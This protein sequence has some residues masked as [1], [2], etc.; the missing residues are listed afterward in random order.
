MTKAG[1]PIRAFAFVI[2]SWTVCRIAATATLPIGWAVALAPDRQLYQRLTFDIPLSAA[3]DLRINIRN[4]A[5][6]RFATRPTGHLHVIIP[7]SPS[8]QHA[9]TYANSFDAADDLPSTP[10]RISQQ[11]RVAALE[12]RLEPVLSST[13]ENRRWSMD[14]WALVRNGGSQNSLANY[15]QLG[16]SQVGMR[17]Q[18]DLT[19]GRDSRVALYSRLSRA[20][21]S[22][23]A[24]EAALGVTYR[25]KR[26]LPLDIAIERRISLGIGARNAFAIIGATGFGPTRM[27]LGLQGEGYAQAGFVGFRTKDHFVDGKIALSKSVVGDRIAIGLA[28]S[29]GAQRNLT[30]LDIGPHIHMRFSTG[31]IHSR[32]AADWR[33]RIIGHAQPGSGP[34]I[35]LATSF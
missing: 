28:A 4:K 34:A 33:Q 11:Y 10:K 2:L 9:D 24:P 6:P 25:P 8:M 30:R 17:L 27:P 31:K 1:R 19:P 26:S 14:V 7:P 35:T 23:Y 5:I 20:L 29:G 16:A 18:Y 21:E 3:V 12:P 13:R 22:P 15:G 32:L